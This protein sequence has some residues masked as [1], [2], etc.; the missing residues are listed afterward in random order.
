MAESEED[1]KFIR[2]NGRIIPIK[3]TMGVKT[4][5][6]GSG[7]SNMD[8][9]KR[10][11]QAASPKPGKNTA[12]QRFK[13]GYA[14][15]AWAGVAIGALTNGS[16][17]KGAAIGAGLGGIARVALGSKNVQEKRLS[18]AE[19]IFTATALVGA[20]MMGRKALGITTSPFTKARALGIM[21]RGISKARV[22]RTQKGRSG[23]VIFGKFPK[24]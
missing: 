3:D 14:R 1:M 12:L 20:T 21:K 15:G 23:N 16:I 17:L 10:V 5:K 9:A 24:R 7:E 2:K 22:W 8:A 13:T 18:T 19:H 4:T 11:A 6:V